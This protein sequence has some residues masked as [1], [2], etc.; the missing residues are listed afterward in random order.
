MAAATGLLKRDAEVVVN[1]V[2][3]TMAEAIRSGSPIELRGFGSFRFRNRPA[4]VGRNP[5][6]GAEVRVPAKRIC[7]FKPGRVLIEL[8]NS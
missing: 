1:A 2:L 4:R 8:V 3:E 7:Y 6:T 5:K